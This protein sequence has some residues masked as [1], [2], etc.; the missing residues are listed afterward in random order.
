MNTLRKPLMQALCVLMAFF[1][2]LLAGCSTPTVAMTVDGEEISTGEYLA[3]LY[4]HFYS[5]YYSSGLYQYAQ[6]GQDPWEQTMEYGEGDE[7]VSM[8]LGDYLVQITKDGIIRQKAVKNM[9]EAHNIPVEEEA[10]NTFLESLEDYHENEMIVYGF[11]K[12]HYKEMYIAQNLNEQSLF[13]GLYDE[14][15]ERAVAEKDI[16]DFFDKNYVAYKAITMSLT[17]SEGEE[18]S[19]AEKQEVKD[20]LNTYLEQYEESG[21]FSAVISQYKVDTSSTTATTTTT[22]A[23]NT[24]TTAASGNASD[25]GETTTAAPATTTTAAASTTAI[26]TT[27][28]APT[29]TTKAESTT[30]AEGGESEETTTTAAGGDDED[31]EE[32]K[33]PDLQMVNSVEG[34]KAIVEAVQKIPENTAQI[35]EYTPTSGSLTAALVLRLN[36]EEQ[37]GE[38]YYEDE[39]QR[40][41]YGL[42]YEEFD[43]EVQ[44]A[45]DALTVTYNDRAISMCDPKNFLDAVEQ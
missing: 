25:D 11:N 26:T 10:L 44:E 17:D 20:Q 28:V 30:A 5:A 13:Y 8:K 42:R 29:T 39:H 43:K 23:G 19:D 34:D 32:E 41:I 36:V 2:L 40:C 4:N 15:G 33:D 3:N 7:A 12:E 18:M 1:T 14:G 22:A 9:M 35:I 21:D 24:G 37:G 38:N 27:T 31:E 45:A 6:Y 16:R